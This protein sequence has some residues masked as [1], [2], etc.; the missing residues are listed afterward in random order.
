MRWSAPRRAVAIIARDDPTVRAPWQE[1]MSCGEQPGT[2]LA[3]AAAGGRRML[4][5]IKHEAAEHNIAR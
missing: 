1:S 2:M 4:R 3:E 5:D